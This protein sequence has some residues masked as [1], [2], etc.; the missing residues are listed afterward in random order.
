MIILQIILLIQNHSASLIFQNGF[1]ILNAAV[2]DVNNG[3]K[4]NASRNAFS[5]KLRFLPKRSFVTIELQI[6]GN[7]S[8]CINIHGQISLSRDVS[9]DER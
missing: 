5:R 6:A 1:C 2:S 4:L 8:R 7:I 3:D 9:R